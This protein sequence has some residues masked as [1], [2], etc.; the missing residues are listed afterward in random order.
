MSFE[1]R[2]IHYVANPC[3]WHVSNTINK[4]NAIIFLH[5][6]FSLVVLFSLKYFH[7]IFYYFDMSICIRVKV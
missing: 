7:T 1:N 6:F 3:E 2:K 4:E 5:I